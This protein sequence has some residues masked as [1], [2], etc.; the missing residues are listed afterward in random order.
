MGYRLLRGEG[1]GTGIISPE[2]DTA[3]LIPSGKSSILLLVIGAVLMFVY[4][5][6]E[7]RDLSASFY[8]PC[9]MPLISLIW[10]SAILICAFAYAKSKS[11][12]F[13]T[14]SI[15]LC[16]GLLFKILLFDFSFWRISFDG[17]RFFVESLAV[18][19]SMRA[20]NFLM[21]AGAFAG[22]FALFAG[23]SKN[24]AGFFAVLC[25]SIL[26]GYSTLELN[27]FLA[28]KAPLFRAGGI[29]ILWGLFALSFVLSGIKKNV[30]AL[31]YAGLLIFTIIVFKVFFSDLSRLSQLYRIIA[32][33]SLGL[34]V[35]AGS[36]IY[37]KFK[38]SFKIGDKNE[39]NPN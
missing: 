5:H 26:F 19:T 39:K 29:S 18:E 1:D 16:F 20:I 38:D 28:Y 11:N 2:N 9:K 35:L 33:I 27:T 10:T 30:K 17:P 6:F 22:A 12:A 31:R 15:L 36:F 21:I 23:K 7:F 37:I 8:P 34:L 3:E 25:L 24:V 13:I 4:L 14:V 32:F